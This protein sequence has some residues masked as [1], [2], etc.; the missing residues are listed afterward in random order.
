MKII[1]NLLLSIFNNIGDSENNSIMVVKNEADLRKLIEDAQKSK[2]N[3]MASSG[4]IPFGLSTQADMGIGIDSDNVIGTMCNFNILEGQHGPVDSLRPIFY[5]VADIV[6]DDNFHMLIT[7][8]I[9]PVQGTDFYAL[10][11]DMMAFGLRGI[12]SRLEHNIEEVMQIITFD[13][14]LNTGGKKIETPII[15]DSIP[16]S[17]ETTNALNNKAEDK[18]EL[19]EKAKP[20][21]S[22]KTTRTPRAPRTPKTPTTKSLLE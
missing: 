10:K 19:E 14:I 3:P 9:I 18:K 13:L 15:D 17:I 7:P 16:A 6:I 5:L 8:M 4:I 20:E 21:K 2:L 12:T 11:S 22:K 1:K